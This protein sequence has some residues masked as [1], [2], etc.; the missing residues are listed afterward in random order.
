MQCHI[1]ICSHHHV[2]RVLCGDVDR[3]VRKLL[4]VGIIIIRI[5]HNAQCAH[6]VQ[7]LIVASIRYVRIYEL[8]IRNDFSNIKNWKKQKRNN[9]MLNWKPFWWHCDDCQIKNSIT[10]QKGNDKQEEKEEEWIEHNTGASFFKFHF[11]S[12]NVEQ[13]QW[14]NHTFDLLTFNFH[15]QCNAEIRCFNLSYFAKISLRTR[16]RKRTQEH[17]RNIKEHFVT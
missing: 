17:S 10:K 6:I 1:T 9:K 15:R 14:V 12:N 13:T 7:P 3:A 2:I 5:Q 8:N 4:I 11:I 16:M